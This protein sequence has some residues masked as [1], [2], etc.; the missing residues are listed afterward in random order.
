MKFLETTIILFTLMVSFVGCTSSPTA[1]SS[2]VESSYSGEIESFYVTPTRIITQSAQVEN[3]KVLL[4]EGRHQAYTGLQNLCVME[5]NEAGRAF[6]VL[7]FG[8]EWHGGISLFTGI[9]ST[10]E[11]IK[12]RIRLGES[13]SEAMSELG[14]ELNATN[15]HAIRDWVQYLPWCGQVQVGNSGFRFASIELLDNDVE[16]RLREISAVAVERNLEYKGSFESN[17]ERLNQIWKTGARTVHLNMQQYLWDGPKRDRLVW[18]G[19]MHPEVRT[20]L[21]VFGTQDVVPHSL[22]FIKDTTPLPHWMNGISS[23]SMWWIIIHHEWYM[24][25]GD[26]SLLQENKD[27]ILGLLDHL[28]KFVDAE[29]CENLNGVRFLDWP[30]KADTP[31]VHAGL[32]SMM[33]MT[34]EV[35]KELAKILDAEDKCSKYDDVLTLLRNHS[36]EIPHRKSP[37]AL[38]SIAELADSHNVCENYLLVDSVQDISTF[39]GYYV[40][41]A[42]GDAGY[43]TQALD[44]IRI[45]W[46][47]MLDLGATTFWE[48]FDIDW[49]KNA[50]RID[51]IVPEGKIDIHSAYGAYCYKGFRHSL[52]HGWASG[53]TAWLTQY[54]LGVEVVEPGCKVIKID[55]HLGDLDWVKGTYPTP[56]GSVLIEHRKDDTGK[57]ITQVDAPEGIRCIVVD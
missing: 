49:I 26:L 34:F 23:Y 10:K 28:S 33:V 1:D 48:D 13:V 35:G 53:P 57:I 3:A 47:A 31:S 8:K 51:E 44:I 6:I 2:M 29:G 15:D 24:H 17:D 36:V 42:L 46:G 18:V 45:Y 55:P 7:D 54:V 50:A 27:Y 52:C 43:C 21:S 41:N 38:M 30:T 12:V 16:L 9:N 39:Y 25:S 11:A 22:D 19:D 14:G 4:Q 56:H 37:A 32:Q 40:L 20:I 5:N